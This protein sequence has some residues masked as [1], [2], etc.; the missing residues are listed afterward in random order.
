MEK[1]MIENGWFIQNMLIECFAFVVRFSILRSV[2]V[3]WR[4]MVLEIGNISMIGLK[5]MRLVWTILPT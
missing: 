2:R 3:H 4:M 5:N 1:F